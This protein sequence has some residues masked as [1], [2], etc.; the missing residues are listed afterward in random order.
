MARL[1]VEE[2]ALRALNSLD[3]DCR[4]QGEGTWWSRWMAWEAED[5]ER[6]SCSGTHNS[7]TGQVLGD[8]SNNTANSASPAWQQ[9]AA[10]VPIDHKGL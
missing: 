10:A 7:R 4:A 2:H 6:G 1:G 8:D 3:E 9:S 5:V